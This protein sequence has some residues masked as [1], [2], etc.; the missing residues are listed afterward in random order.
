M[1]ILRAWKVHSDRKTMGPARDKGDS[2][3][4]DGTAGKSGVDFA[5]PLLIFGH[6]KIWQV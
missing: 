4:G 2:G 5:N 3:L 6:W 1:V